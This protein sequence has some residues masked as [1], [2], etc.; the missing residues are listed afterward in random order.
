V[1]LEQNPDKTKIAAGLACGMLWTI[2]KG[3]QIGDVVLCPDGKG[4]Y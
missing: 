4:N 2:S 3:I 1:F